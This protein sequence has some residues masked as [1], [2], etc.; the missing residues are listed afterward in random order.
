SVTPRWTSDSISS[1]SEPGSTT[2]PQPITQRRPLCRIPEG[3]VW[4]TYFSR[5]TTTVWPALLPPEK[6]TTTLTCGVMMSTTLPLPSSPHCAPITTMLGI[7][8][9][10]APP[11]VG[12]RVVQHLAHRQHPLVSAR[13][14]QRQ[15]LVGPRARAADDQHVAGPLCAG[16]GHRLL[17]LPGEDVARHRG[18]TIPQPPRQRERH[19][20]LPREVDDEEVGPRQLDLHA[21]GV[22]HRQHPADV[23]GEAD[24]RALVPEPPQHVIVA[25]AGRHRGAEAGHV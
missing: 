18:A 25:P 15:Q 13:Q 6:R 2:T 7:T 8:A 21:L 23:E 14:L 5:P 11:E 17:E 22:H 9:L 16:V 19:G 1:M 3:I 4:R 24:R 20:L 10:L 12:L